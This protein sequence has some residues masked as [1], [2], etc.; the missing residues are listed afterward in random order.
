MEMNLPKM[1]VKNKN[2][3][4]ENVGGSIPQELDFFSKQT[5]C[6]PLP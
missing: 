2:Q 5:V 4:P 6:S 1:L 3:K